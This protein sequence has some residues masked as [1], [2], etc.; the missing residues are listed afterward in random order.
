MVRLCGVGSN[1]CTNVSAGAQRCFR[2]LP[3][4]L[5]TA[6]LAAA[7]A[8]CA[9]PPVG[10]ATDECAASGWFSRADAASVQAFWVEVLSWPASRF[11]TSC[12][13]AADKPGL[14]IGERFRLALAYAAPNNPRRDP[15]QTRALLAELGPSTAPDSQ[16]A[17]RLIL[18]LSDDAQASE[19]RLARL[20]VQKTQLEERLRAEQERAEVEAR[21]ATDAQRR[22]V[23]GEERSRESERRFAEV[24]LRLNDA[25]RRLDGLKSVEDAINRRAAMRRSA[26]T[27]GAAEPV[28]APR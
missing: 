1:A 3:S 25:T 16:V 23:L 28:S 14:Q 8:G 13:G 19:Q 11:E 20:E 26:A 18:R 2:P 9:A 6:A 4:A 22:A 7:L 12:L 24:N 21:R 10:S 27:G 15:G 17:A 5:L